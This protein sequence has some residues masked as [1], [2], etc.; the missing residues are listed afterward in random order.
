M[1]I[2]CARVCSPSRLHFNF[3]VMI[4]ENLPLHQMVSFTQLIFSVWHG[5]YHGHQAGG[6]GRNEDGIL[7]GGTDNLKV[8]WE[9]NLC[10]LA[11]VFDKEDDDH[12]DFVVRSPNVLV[13]LVRAVEWDEDKLNQ[14]VFSLVIQISKGVKFTLGHLFWILVSEFWTSGQGK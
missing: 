10:H 6:E 1:P 3:E 11:A 12:S 8:V 7:G 4:M 2:I 5:N 13:L 9:F 14:F